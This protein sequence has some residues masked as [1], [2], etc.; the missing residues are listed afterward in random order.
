MNKS[1]GLLVSFP[2]CFSDS[3]KGA[4]GSPIHRLFCFKDFAHVTYIS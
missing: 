2:N 4:G 3:K 1:I